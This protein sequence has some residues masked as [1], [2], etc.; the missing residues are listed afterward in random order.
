M[1]T[2]SVAPWIAALASAG[3]AAA[4]WLAPAGAPTTTVSLSVTTQ[5]RPAVARDEPR[6]ELVAPKPAHD[7]AAEEGLFVEHGG[8]YWPS[9]VVARQSDGRVKI[10]YLGWSS[11]SDEVVEAN[12]IRR[13]SSTNAGHLM[14]EWHG[15]YWPATA[16]RSDGSRTFIRYDGYGSEWDE[17]VGPERTA[18]FSW[19]SK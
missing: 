7:D 10:H 11:E 15:S 5:P 13:R 16:L 4:A 17:W 9:S 1:S 19:P 12:R 6:P 8:S 14:V 3:V 18:R 2:A